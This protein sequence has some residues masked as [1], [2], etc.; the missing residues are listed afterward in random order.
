MR[1]RE[2]AHAARLLVQRPAR[3]R[4]QR[5]L[6]LAI[7]RGAVDDS[8]RLYL[9]EDVAALGITDACIAQEKAAPLERLRKRRALY[10]PARPPIDP[11]GRLAIVVDD[12]IATG[13]SVR[14]A[15]AK[16]PARLVAAGG[17]AS[18]EA[19]E[20]LRL[21]AD[22]VVCVAVPEV[23]DAVGQFFAEFRPVSDAQVAAIL[24]QRAAP[25]M[26]PPP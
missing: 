4:G 23:F 6:V 22:A 21:E 15:R 13:A 17:V 12:G 2:R 1:F 11:A 3:Y 18:R 26:P 8:G 14:A 16:R 5:P 20:R 9:S 7:P 25:R 24:R 19:V 10:T